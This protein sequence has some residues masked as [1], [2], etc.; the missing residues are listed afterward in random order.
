MP[1]RGGADRIRS[2]IDDPGPD[3]ESDPA[4]RPPDL[5]AADCVT[6]LPTHGQPVTNCFETSGAKAVIVVGSTVPMAPAEGI[7]PFAP[8]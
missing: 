7:K 1:P 5:C 2:R 3:R 6:I 8:T 4:R